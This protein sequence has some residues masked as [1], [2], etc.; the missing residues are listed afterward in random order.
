MRTALAAAIGLLV[1]TGI[2]WGQAAPG[3][4]NPNALGVSRVVEID[5]TGGPGFG[6]EHFKAYDFLRDH[7]VVL[8]FDD[9]PWPHNTPAVLKAL[10]DQCT[11]ALFFPIGKHASWH[12]ELLKQV[13]VGQAYMLSDGK[14]RRRAP[15]QPAP[16]PEYCSR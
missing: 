9:G 1:G 4:A 11:K 15:G 3:C 2:A 7:E 10:A 14:W 6:F 5:T 8:T 12:P 16:V 13:A